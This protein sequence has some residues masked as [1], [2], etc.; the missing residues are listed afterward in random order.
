MIDFEKKVIEATT[1]VQS[2]LGCPVSFHPGRNPESPFEII[3][4]FQE[5][6][7]D[8]SKVAMSHLDRTIFDEGQLTEF[9]ELG[10]YCEFDL[11]GIECSYYQLNEAIDMPSD[12]QRIQSIWQLVDGNFEDRILLSHDIHTKHR[13]TKFGGHGYTYIFDNVVP[14]MSNRGLSSS[15]V[16]K[17]LVDNPKAWLTFK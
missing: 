2:E 6:G 11:F 9:A 14:K 7:G 3:R 8:V 13:L 16:K 5:A 1:L 10:C 12:A 17:F 15:I 4:I